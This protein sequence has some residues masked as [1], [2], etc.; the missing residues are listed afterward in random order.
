MKG[1][2]GAKLQRP[3]WFVRSQRSVAEAFDLSPRT[4]ATWLRDGAP[5]AEGGYYDLLELARWRGRREGAGA[6]AGGDTSE[7]LPTTWKDRKARADAL[8]AELKQR[9]LEGELYS[10]ERIVELTRQRLQLFTTTLD[11]LCSALPAE[12]EGLT[13]EEAELVMRRDVHAM[14]QAFCDGEDAWLTLLEEWRVRGIEPGKKRAG[15]P[16]KG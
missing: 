10:G 8:M 15:R 13:K 11:A 6:G 3:A 1:K 4:I 5:R 14:L 2:G 12:L 16:M 9:E 7:E